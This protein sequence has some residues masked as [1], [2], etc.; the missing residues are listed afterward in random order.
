MGV[1]GP[2]NR[3]AVKQVKASDDHMRQLIQQEDDTLT[4]LNGKPYTVAYHGL[5]WQAG[6]GPTEASTAFLVMG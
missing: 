6:V 1:E 3:V 4:K 5:F 2:A